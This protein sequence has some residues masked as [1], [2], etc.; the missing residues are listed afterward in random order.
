MY[1]VYLI[2]NTKN[3]KLYV[4]ITGRPL[5][6]RW[7]EHCNR[8]HYLHEAIKKYGENSFDKFVL[9]KVSSKDKALKLEEKYIELFQTYEC[10]YNLTRRG[11]GFSRGEEHYLADY[12]DEEV[13]EIVNEYRTSRKSR[14]EI[15]NK[16]DISVDCLQCWHTG[17]NRT[18]LQNEFKE[19][20]NTC[21]GGISDETAVE[22]VN[23]FRT[24][25]KSLKEVSKEYNIT[26]GALEGWH[27]GNSRKELQK[28]FAECKRTSQSGVSDEEIVEAVN[29]YRTTNKSLSE[30]SK[31]FNWLG[32]KGLHKYHKGSC[33]SNLQKHFVGTKK[34]KKNGILDKT[35]VEAIVEYKMTNKTQKEVANSYNFSGAFL[36]KCRRGK[37]R[38]YIQDK[39][40]AR[41]AYNS[42]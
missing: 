22:A 25:K 20:K 17:Q 21:T 42:L 18:Y 24:T 27:Y 3:Y 33:R 12:K 1:T 15:A 38:S 4:G 36:S 35:I 37:K 2:E 11:D 40:T 39:V 9:K 32:K 16:Y 10:G 8:G 29:E 34:D 13:I 30:V 41:L 19:N 14:K 28:K 7:N 26:K 5:K 31:N 6:I 23:E